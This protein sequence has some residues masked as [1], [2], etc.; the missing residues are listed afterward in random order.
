MFND[1]IRNNISLFV[2][3][4]SDESIKQALED[5]GLSKLIE[6]LPDGLDTVVEENG[7]NFSGGERQ[8]L[9]LARAFL[10]NR[11]ILIL[12]EGTSAVD[13]VIAA[14]IEDRLLNDRNLTL[15]AITHNVSEEHLRRFDSSLEIGS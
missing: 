3:S 2:K 8:R 13:A 12:D 7:S 11:P 15:I 9:S 6:S 14:D 10:R 4:F 5:A 1:T